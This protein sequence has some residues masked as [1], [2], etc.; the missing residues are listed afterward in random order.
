MSSTTSACVHSLVLVA[1]PLK[2]ASGEKQTACTRRS[3][4]SPSPPRT[5]GDHSTPAK[6]LFATAVMYSSK[7]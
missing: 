2:S 1:Q 7:A 4:S 3:M 5:S 6:A